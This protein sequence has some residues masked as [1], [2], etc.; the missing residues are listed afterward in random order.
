VNG[1]MGKVVAGFSVAGLV[2]GLV[3]AQLSAGFGYVFPASP[4][5]LPISLLLLLLGLANYL[6]SFPIY[7][8]R[9]QLGLYK[10]G[11]RPERPNPFYAVRVLILARASVLA[12]ALFAGWHAG[13]LIWLVSFSVAPEN[14]ILSSSFGL[15]GAVALTIGGL[16]SKRNCKTPPSSDS[17]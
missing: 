2:L 4:S 12:G 1:S 7:R 9:K 14:L 6:F 16:V 17:D 13:L 15:V 11:V 8:Y 5:S 3:V 10:E